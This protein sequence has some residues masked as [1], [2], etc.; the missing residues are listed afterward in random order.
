V[1]GALMETGFP[2]GFATLVSM[3]DG[4]TSLYL[5][6]GGGMLGEGANDRVAAATQSFVTAVEDH[7]GLLSPDPDSDPPAAGR[8]I[9]RALTYQ[10]RF[11]AEAAV[12]DLGHG[13]HPLSAVFHAGEGVLNELTA[14]DQAR[15][16]GR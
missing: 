11:R 12:D 9:I 14:I 7:L 5:S 1:W 3:V 2:N 4:A 6:N 8:V 10:G 13:R 16:T 15:Q